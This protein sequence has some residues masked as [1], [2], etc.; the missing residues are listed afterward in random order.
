MQHL[1][2]LFTHDFAVHRA[3]LYGPMML[4]IGAAVAYTATFADNVLDDAAPL[5]A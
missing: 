3:F 5:A 1:K 4:A 2:R